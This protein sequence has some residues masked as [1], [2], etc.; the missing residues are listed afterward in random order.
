MIPM[1]PP[2]RLRSARVPCTHHSRQLPRSAGMHACALNLFVCGTL[3]PSPARTLARSHA[4]HIQEAANRRATM[5]GRHYVGPRAQT[6]GSAT[7]VARRCMQHDMHRCM[8]GTHAQSDAS[9][10]W[11]GMA[12][13]WHRHLQGASHAD[14]LHTHSGPGEGNGKSED[15]AG[16]GGHCRLLEPLFPPVNYPPSVCSVSKAEPVNRCVRF[17]EPGECETDPCTT[18][19]LSACSGSDVCQWRRWRSNA[20]ARANS[21]CNPIRSA[22]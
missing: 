10:T 15:I 20:H 6:C 22:H 1:E 7:S 8:H 3:L 5:C 4:R 14:T 21:Q 9:Q 13:A 2:R 18:E 16:R 17:A 11:H 12:S 19:W